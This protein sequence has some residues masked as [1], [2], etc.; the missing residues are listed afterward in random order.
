MVQYNISFFFSSR[1]RHTSCALVT[2][3]Q[4]CAL[5]IYA[6][7]AVNGLL[8]HSGI[9]PGIQDK[10]VVGFGQVQAG[11]ACLNGYKE[12]LYFFVGADMVYHTASF[13]GGAIKIGI[14]DSVFVE[15]IAEEVQMADEL[16]VDRRCTRLNSSH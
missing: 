6:V 2:G 7:G 8:F 16:R 9:P 13:F 12:G 14:G 3:V 15:G 11:A 4:T 10:N 5:P 1:R